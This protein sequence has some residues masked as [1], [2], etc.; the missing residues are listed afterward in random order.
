[1]HRFPHVC[2]TCG[3]RTVISE[4]S[5]TRCDTVIQ[6]TYTGCRFCTL[7]DE[8]LRFLELFIGSRG[9]LKEMERETGL[10]YWTIRGKLDDLIKTL[11][12]DPA[13][14]APADTHAERQAILAA[15]AAGEL[16]VA[17]AEQRLLAL[18]KR[19]SSQS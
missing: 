8:D 6:G 13:T 12:L 16:S 14:A 7:P 17:E 11:R 5:C 10:G 2:P 4:V 15:V 9:N 1:M 19:A 18:A 3:G